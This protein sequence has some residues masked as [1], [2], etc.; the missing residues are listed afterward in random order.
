MSVAVNVVELPRYGMVHFNANFSL[1]FPDGSVYLT[2]SIAAVRPQGD[3]VTGLQSCREIMLRSLTPHTRYKPDGSCLSRNARSDELLGLAL[4]RLYHGAVPLIQTTIDSDQ[5]RLRVLLSN[6]GVA[7][8]APLIGHH[9]RN[10]YDGIKAL[11]NFRD[12]NNQLPYAVAYWA[13]PDVAKYIDGLKLPSPYCFG[14]TVS[15]EGLTSPTTGYILS[16]TN[17]ERYVALLPAAIAQ[18]PAFLHFAVGMFR[19]VCFNY[20]SPKSIQIIL[21]ILDELPPISDMYK[22]GVTLAAWL[23]FKPNRAQGDLL[24]SLLQE[25]MGGYKG[26]LQLYRL[27]DDLWPYLEKNGL[28]GWIPPKGAERP[29]GIGVLSQNLIHLGGAVGAAKHIAQ[30]VE[31]SP[32]RNRPSLEQE[33]AIYDN[34][35]EGTLGTVSGG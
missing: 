6:L 22:P 20:T 14:S 30:F 29:Y 28:V 26:L 33:Q 21:S 32:L 17:Y 24:G 19:A 12:S 9:G 18:H 34:V 13:P 35:D 11:Q 10:F 1:Y 27:S 5:L 15:I 3:P 2:S 23:K 4:I 8:I 31:N 16:H 25:L 7:L